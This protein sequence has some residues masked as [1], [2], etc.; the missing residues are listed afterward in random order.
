MLSLS[1][2]HGF[3]SYVSSLPPAVHPHLEYQLDWD[4]DVD[5]DLR[6]I[7]NHMLESDLE[8]LFAHLKL[9]EEDRRDVKKK[10]PKPELQRCDDSLA[11]TKVTFVLLIDV[12]H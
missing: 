7:A 4:N 5:T 8:E 6:E 2:A 3:A 10:H 1:A 12:R 9:A 11:V